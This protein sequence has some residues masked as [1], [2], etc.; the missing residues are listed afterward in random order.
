MTFDGGMI[1]LNVRLSFPEDQPGVSNN[2]GIQ[3]T[4]VYGS[5]LIVMLVAHALLQIFRVTIMDWN[6]NNN[7]SG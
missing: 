4:V 3:S 6:Y 2:G 5:V 1:N 7:H